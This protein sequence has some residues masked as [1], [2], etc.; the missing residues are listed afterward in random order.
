MDADY[1]PI[2]RCDGLNSWRESAA[3]TNFEVGDTAVHT[4][5]DDATKMR[6]NAQ[7][8]RATGHT[9][10]VQVLHKWKT[11]PTNITPLARYH[12]LNETSLAN[13]VDTVVCDILPQGIKLLHA[14]FRVECAQSLF[15]GCPVE[16]G[17]LPASM[18][19]L[20]SNSRSR[21][22]ALP[23]NLRGQTLIGPVDLISRYTQDKALKVFIDDAIKSLKKPVFLPVTHSML[24]QTDVEDDAVDAAA[25]ILIHAAQVLLFAPTRW[26]KD[27]EYT[28]HA[29]D[30]PHRYPTPPGHGG[31]CRTVAGIYSLE[32]LH[33][34]IL[35]VYLAIY[36]R[37][38]GTN[39]LIS[40]R[41]PQS[42]GEFLGYFDVERQIPDE[43]EE[44]EDVAQLA[45]ARWMEHPLR[46][47]QKDSQQ[48]SYIITPSEPKP[49][50]GLAESHSTPHEQSTDPQERDKTMDL[51]TLVRERFGWDD[52]DQ[53]FA[54]VSEHRTS[55]DKLIGDQHLSEFAERGTASTVVQEFLE[56]HPEDE[57]GL[58]EAL[59]RSYALETVFNG[60]PPPED[61]DI[62]TVCSRFGIKPYPSL[63]LYPDKGLQPLKPH[64]VADLGVIFE[65][66]DS[67]GHVLFSNEMGLGKTKVFMSMIEC[68]ARELEA[69]FKS[70]LEGESKA[71]F[72]PTLIVNPPSTIHQT[73]SEMQANFPGLNV[74]LYYSHRNV[75]YK[76]NSAK[77]V[78]RDELL[79]VLQRLSNTN[80]QTARTVVMTTY[81]TLYR[82]DISRT[83]RHF[84]F[85]D[86]E[87]KGPAAKRTRTATLAPTDGGGPVDD[88]VMPGSM[89]IQDCD[90]ENP[91]SLIGCYTL[92]QMRRAHARR[93][94]ENPRIQNYYKGDPELKGKRL[95]FL[96]PGER[97]V[98]DGNLVEYKLVLP[99]LGD[100]KWGFLIVTGTPLMSSLKDI[101]S[102][103]GLIWAKLGI[104][105]VPD[106]DMDIGYMQGLW[107]EQY[108]P[109]VDNTW[110]NGEE[111]KGIF[112]ETFMESCP[113]DAWTQMQDFYRRT[114]VKVW[115]IN[116]S[117]LARAGHQAE[118]S[119][120]FG[121]KVVSV[122]LKTVSLRRTP[123]SRLILPDGQVSFPAAD[124]LPMTIITEELRFDPARRDLVQEHGRNIA[125][126]TFT[127]APSVP[128]QNLTP[129]QSIPANGPSVG[130]LNFKAYREGV[131]VA[132]DWRNA[133]ILGSDMK[134]IFDGP[135][136]AVAKALGAMNRRPTKKSMPTIGADHV[137]KLLQHDRNAGLDYF[138]TRTCGDP[139][140]L[141]LT[142]RA[143]WLHWL[144]A[145][146]PILARTLELCHR[147]VHEKKERVLI[148]VDTPWIQQLMY[149]ALLMAGFKTLTVRSLDDSISRV[150]A[151]ESFSDPLSDSQI[152]V[153][154][155]NIISTGV[156]LHHACCFGILATLHYNAKTLQQVHGRLHRLGQR[157]AV[158]WHSLKVR[159][160][161]HDHQ[162]RV[163]LTKW[164]RQLSAEANLP[165]WMTG[166]LREAVL[167]ELIRSCWNHP[168][169][170]YAW[171]I[172]HDRDGSP[173]AY[174]SEEAI[175]LGYACSVVAK[176]AVTTERR[177]FWTDN[178]DYLAT[179]LLEMVGQYS[180]T[181]TEGW[182]KL[183]EAQLQARLER[184]VESMIN[185]VK[186][187][188]SKQEQV[189]LL[190]RK[191][192]E[193]RGDESAEFIAAGDSE[194]EDEAGAAGVEED[195]WEEDVEMR[196]AE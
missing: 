138:F 48:P 25:T 107:D 147:Y 58:H 20:L 98:P 92:I 181:E 6:R 66:L 18:D 54:W 62:N 89:I 134:H 99:A 155:I 100:V 34:A 11:E 30:Y 128:L 78:H 71:I 101:M 110:P 166:A 162:E 156:N 87:G 5:D 97:G 51:Q 123:R 14:R 154:N 126:R 139:D 28:V 116:P 145:T 131:L 144:A 117:L 31:D 49:T 192:E 149:G 45:I 146:S 114:G 189:Q 122:V 94:E 44:E 193:R 15:G 79:G 10:G 23:S 120:S 142:E 150:K 172:L 90:W 46:E 171:V 194:G 22:N 133:K 76:S 74:L 196:E 168:F 61:T 59:L 108:D 127:A 191:L 68:R 152:F 86:R 158:V 69:K 38:K 77:I 24:S 177:E 7:V 26:H 42:R 111:T 8:W 129:S 82:R 91:G 104:Q 56:L 112:N 132:Y 187:T 195:H 140:V 50:A 63:E 57:R 190:K 163:L 27:I 174:Y 72:F 80:P 157:K 96:R 33:R 40:S 16:P 36:R 2:L 165:K 175:K 124:L 182:L 83:E 130:W 35:M 4:P 53:V 188:E 118:W 169:N 184:E 29:D 153:A 3:A 43:A 176:L 70:L 93:A 102:P 167:F 19:A 41:Q 141:T 88:A 1:T 52:P 151:I 179:A 12:G 109:H 135:F 161:F 136:D 47:P 85:L 148:Y 173:M 95:H 60:H 178:D 103:L 21:I 75:W 170:R 160:S 67:L 186:G 183:G 81:N 73:H 185:S 164:S 113:S 125:T 84:V 32:D 55:F 119:S 37:M 106:R 143:S 159:D 39:A 115:Q 64:Q 65:K 17:P 121:Q 137:Q 13:F 105:P 180:V 9:I